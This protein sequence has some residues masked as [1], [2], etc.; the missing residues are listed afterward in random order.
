MNRRAALAETAA[1][2][3]SVDG[4]VWLRSMRS[5]LGCSAAI[6]LLVALSACDDGSDRQS[7]WGGEPFGN[8]G[9]SQDAAQDVAAAAGRTGGAGAIQDSGRAGASPNDDAGQQPES[10]GSCTPGS[11]LA[12]HRCD[13]A[14]GTCVQNAGCTVDDVAAV[15]STAIADMKSDKK[16]PEDITVCGNPI[17]LPSFLELS[18]TAVLEIHDGTQGPVQ[19]KAF[20]PPIAPQDN[21]HKGT[22]AKPE[23]VDIAARVKNYMN[24]N[25]R[26]PN[27]ASSTSLGSQMGYTNLVC[28]YGKVLDYYHSNGKLP[29]SVALDPAW[30]VETAQDFI[31]PTTTYVNNSTDYGTPWVADLS[32]RHC[33]ED[34]DGMDAGREVMAV[35]AGVVRYAQDNDDGWMWGVVV[36]HTLA[37]GDKLTSVYW[38]LASREVSV[39]QSVQ[40]GQRIGEIANLT[41]SNPHLHFGI[42]LAPYDPML[43]TEGALENSIFPEKF[44]DPTAFVDSH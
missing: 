38:H 32:Q 23:Y 42:R 30:M 10:S 2:S 28:L 1:E 5:C 29:D 12:G 27:Y 31:R 35:E 9:A 25:S 24:A 14:S 19:P 13:T 22:V 7:N 37:S 17:R 44:V 18:L 11:C 4:I 34:V 39:G 3:Q 21:I 36:E 40:R 6:C 20:Q 8:G 33:G 26:A 43:S 15:A 41:R 16:L